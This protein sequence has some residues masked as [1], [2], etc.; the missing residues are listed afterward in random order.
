MDFAGA[1]QTCFSD[2]GR[3]LLEFYPTAKF[4]I[5]GE[6]VHVY[7]DNAVVGHYDFSTGTGHLVDAPV[8]M[9]PDAVGRFP[10]FT[11]I[12]IDTFIQ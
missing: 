8:I 2:W 3:T 9:T 7:K 5:K 12:D 1:Q 11:P 10:S 4:N 6:R